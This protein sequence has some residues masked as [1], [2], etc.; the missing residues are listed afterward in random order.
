MSYKLFDL[1]CLFC[2]VFGLA[3]LFISFAYFLLAR[4]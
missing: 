4:F 3:A 2:F 1:F